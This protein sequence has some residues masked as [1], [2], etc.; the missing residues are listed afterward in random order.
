MKVGDAFGNTGCSAWHDS[1]NSSWFANSYYGSIIAGGMWRGGDGLFS[2]YGYYRR[3]ATSWFGA[4][5]IS[6]D[7]ANLADTNQCSRGVAVV[8]SGL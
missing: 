6:E 5:W 4:A 2:Y 3:G 1:K 7:G 8:G